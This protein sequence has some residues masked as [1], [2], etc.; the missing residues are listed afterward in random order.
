MR[1]TEREREMDQQTI[2]VDHRVMAA[3][4]LRRRSLARKSY[5]SHGLIGSTQSPKS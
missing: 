3:Q 4:L 5:S 1:F 2:D